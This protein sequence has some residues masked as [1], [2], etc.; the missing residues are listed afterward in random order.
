[1]TEIEYYDQIKNIIENYEVNKKVRFMQDNH[2]KLLMNWTI[3]KLLVEAQGGMNRAKYGDGLIKKWAIK[4]KANFGNNYSKRNLML[5]RKFYLLYP[6]VN[7][8]RTQLNWTHYRILL[9]IKNENARNYYIN[10]I[11]LNNLS[12]RELED[13]IR[14]RTYE[15]LSYTDKDNIKLITDINNTNLTIEDMIKDPILVKVDSKIDKLDEK[16]LHKYLISMLESRF[17]ELGTGFTLAGHEYKCMIDNHTYKID[18]LFFNVN[19]NCYV[20]VELKTREY[21]PKDIGQLQFYVDY[22]N[23]NVKLE[24][25]NQTIGL[26]I[27]KKKDKYVIEYVTSEDIY[28]TTYKLMI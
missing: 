3:G 17:L 15:R 1:M 5:Y 19:L 20:V 2:E 9:S 28:V 4:L 22:I 11:I 12:T 21:N 26:L 8:L 24:N 7:A 25:H 6:K 16:A 23:K 18:L 10:Q 14:S 13:V 27:V